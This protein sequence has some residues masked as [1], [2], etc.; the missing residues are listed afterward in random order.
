MVG[1]RTSGVARPSGD[2]GVERG[3]TEDLVHACPSAIQ[4]ERCGGEHFV[5]GSARLVSTLWSTP[6]TLWSTPA[7][8]WSTP[9]TLW[10]TPR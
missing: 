2:V 10:S 1:A 9:S 8:L 3:G 5:C 6:I 4:Q 7:T